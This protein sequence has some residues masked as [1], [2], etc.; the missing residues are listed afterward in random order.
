MVEVVAVM[1]GRFSLGEGALL[2]TRFRQVSYSSAR[3]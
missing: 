3:Q 1:W 2:I